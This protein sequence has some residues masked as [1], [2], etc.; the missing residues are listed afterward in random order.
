MFLCCAGQ[1]LFPVSSLRPAAGS[2]D[3]ASPIFP[4]LAARRDL[5]TLSCPSIGRC[6]SAFP[7]S[8]ELEQFFRRQACQSTRSKLANLMMCRQLAWRLRQRGSRSPLR[9]SS[10]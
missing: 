9:L 3:G 7:W 4:Q 10:E 1:A 2:G 6:Y 5:E 8:D